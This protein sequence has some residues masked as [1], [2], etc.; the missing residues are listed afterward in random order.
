MIDCKICGLGSF[1]DLTVAELAGARWGG[2]VFYPPSPRH[3]DVDKARAIADDASNSAIA[4]VALVVMLMMRPL[5]PSWM[6]SAR[7]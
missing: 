6:P 5:M 4:R 1:A 3:I 2:F 7:R